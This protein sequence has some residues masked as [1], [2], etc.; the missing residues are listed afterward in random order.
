M[1]TTFEELK[2]E[3]TEFLSLRELR[4]ETKTRV[5]TVGE[6]RS[7][8]AIVIIYSK[9]SNDVLHCYEIP[10]YQEFKSYNAL[11]KFL[12]AR[13]EKAE[14]ADNFEELASSSERSIERGEATPLCPPTVTSTPIKADTLY[15]PLMKKNL[16]IIVRQSSKDYVID[17]MNCKRKEGL[18]NDS[19]YNRKRI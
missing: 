12:K 4:F 7:G 18:M 3:V 11:V 16:K 8:G 6:R 15:N 13:E 2:S 1:K 5:A 19:L 10:E 14:N 17:M 9:I